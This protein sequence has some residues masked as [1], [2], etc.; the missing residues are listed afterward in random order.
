MKE[1]FYINGVDVV[2]ALAYAL[3]V[4]TGLIIPFLLGKSKK[5]RASGKEVRNEN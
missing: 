4:F 1:Y 5:R 3:G 2:F